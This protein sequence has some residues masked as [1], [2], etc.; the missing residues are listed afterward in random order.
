M[1]EW[2]RSD[3]SRLFVPEMSLPEVLVRSTLVYVGVVL[4][5]RVILKRQAGKVALSDLLVV[6]VVAGISRNPL[7]GTPTRLPTGCW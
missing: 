6:A 1:S 4:L 5:L 2:L 7:S 3:W